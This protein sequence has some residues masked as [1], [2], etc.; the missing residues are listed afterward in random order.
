MTPFGLVHPFQMAVLGA[1]RCSR[2]PH[3]AR[4]AALISLHARYGWAR[5]RAHCCSCMLLMARSREMRRTFQAPMC[6]VM[7]VTGHLLSLSRA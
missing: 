4:A 3:Q 6:R 2:T 7:R 1:G 5:A